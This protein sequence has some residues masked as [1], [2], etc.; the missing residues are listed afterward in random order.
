MICHNCNA[1]KTGDS[2][3][4]ADL[5]VAGREG[6]GEY[7]RDI[8]Y[9]KSGLTDDVPAQPALHKVLIRVQPLPLLGAASSSSELL[10]GEL[11][12]QRNCWSHRVALLRDL[13]LLGLAHISSE[14]KSIV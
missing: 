12:S 11:L 8:S 1:A 3:V 14:I 5:T 9:L 6:W 10:R 4:A 13:D 2:L 7:I